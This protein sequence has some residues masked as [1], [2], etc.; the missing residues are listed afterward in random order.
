L[1]LFID[2]VYYALRQVDRKFNHA[3]YL[4][5][6]L[7][8]IV[9]TVKTLLEAGSTTR[10]PRRYCPIDVILSIN[11]KHVMMNL[12][13]P[14]PTE[15]YR[16]SGYPIA[17]KTLELLLEH[18]ADL[19]NGE[20]FLIRILR[21]AMQLIDRHERE[22]QI[23]SLL[24]GIGSYYFVLDN[25]TYNFM[26]DSLYEMY[27]SLLLAGA[28]LTN[29][30]TSIYV[31]GQ[32]LNFVEVLTILVGYSLQSY[33]SQRLLTVVLGSLT[34]AHVFEIK[35]TRFTRELFTAQFTGIPLWTFGVDTLTMV[36]RSNVSLRL[37]NLARCAI[38]KAMSHRT[39]TG[40]STIGLPKILQNYILMK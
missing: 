10:G 12:M 19:A 7:P 26:I 16:F 20:N 14:L 29:S 11:S 6:N 18:R 13:R 32:I 35:T 9:E 4:D 5:D 33:R 38:I 21:Q 37:Q 3:V 24:L 39:I 30:R 34:P 1:I 40:I 25:L 31:S 36:N 28:R 2:L 27:R 15:N 23:R 8:A 17:V 22:L